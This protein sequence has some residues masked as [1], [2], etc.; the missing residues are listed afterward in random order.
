MRTFA[1]SILVSILAAICVL[2]FSNLVYFFPWYMT[3]VVETFNVSQVVASDNYLKQTYHDDA[4]DRL[5]ER[6]I[7]AQKADQIQIEAENEDGNSVVGYDDAA[8]YEDL[9]ENDKPYRQRGEPVKVTIHAVYPLHIE[10]WGERYEQEI[11]VS[12]SLT[13]TGLKH[14]KDLGYYE[15]LDGWDEV[16]P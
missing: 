15:Y 11:P 13:A 10:L 1:K 5:R 16:E 6:P 7:F 9:P 14:Y 8:Y 4:L 3:L 12:F 2:L